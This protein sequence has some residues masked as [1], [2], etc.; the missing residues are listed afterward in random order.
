MQIACG[1][2]TSNLSSLRIKGPELLTNLHIIESHQTKV[3]LAGK[4]QQL[5]ERSEMVRAEEIFLHERLCE[6]MRTY[7]DAD[8]AEAANK[9]SAVSALKEAI[10]AWCRGL[11]VPLDSS[12]LEVPSSLEDAVNTAKLEYAG[13]VASASE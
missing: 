10:D 11:E 7:V 5:V 8:R 6:L 1:S 2:F 4:V 13:L 12:K 3:G 9:E